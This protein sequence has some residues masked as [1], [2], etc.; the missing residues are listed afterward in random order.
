MTQPGYPAE[1]TAHVPNAPYVV[2]SESE[3]NGYSDS[4]VAAYAPHLRMAPGSTPDPLRL[5][6]RVG[7]EYRP[8]ANEPPARWW[9]RLYADEIA[10][11]SVE[12]IDADGWE[13][14]KGGSGKPAALDPRRN[15]PPE[16]R[17]T[18]RMAPTTYS[19]TRPFDQHAA[20]RLNGTHFSMADHR[21]NYEIGGMAPAYTRRNTYRVD[22]P[23]WDDLYTDM[24]PPESP[25]PAGRIQAVDIPFSISGRHWRLQ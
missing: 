15:P 10:R 2:P 16:P 5:S 22:P 18:S 13:E 12:N 21:R 4:P 14:L 1:Q 23:P 19:F 20:R 11:H 6:Y 8:P 25:P 3:E 24:P 17:P 7:Q 9:Q